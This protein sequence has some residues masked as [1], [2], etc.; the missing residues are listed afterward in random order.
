MF[1]RTPRAPLLYH[2]VACARLPLQLLGTQD[3]VD[4]VKAVFGWL[5]PMSVV[6]QGRI[7]ATILRGREAGGSRAVGVKQRW[8]AEVK[9]S[10][11]YIR[12]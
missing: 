5:G 7:E 2:I 11:R 12:V 1:P 9:S 10:F 6:G 4:V 8:L 3:F